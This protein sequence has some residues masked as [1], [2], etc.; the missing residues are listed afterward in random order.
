MQKKLVFRSLAVALPAALFF[1]FLPMLVHADVPTFSDVCVGPDADC[2]IPPFVVS[3]GIVTITFETQVNA[4]CRRSSTDLQWTGM[5]FNCSG[6]QGTT[7]HNCTDPANFGVGTH[8][9]H[10]ACSDVA[11]FEQNITSDN[12]DVTFTVTAADTTRPTI[13]SLTHNPAGDPPAGSVNFQANASDSGSGVK[14]ISVAEQ[15]N[16]GPFVNVCSVTFA[17]P[18]PSA[19]CSNSSTYAAGDNVTL[20]AFAVDDAGNIS[21]AKSDSFTVTAGGGLTVIAGANPTTITLPGSTSLTGF[22]S[23]GVSPYSYLW[24]KLSGPG[25]VTFS[26]TANTSS[27]SASFSTD[28]TYALRLQVVDSAFAVKTGNV[29]ITVLPAG[30]ALDA[31]AGPDQT[32]ADSDSVPGETNVILDG[33]ASTGPIVVYQWTESGVFL[34]SGKT[35]KLP[36]ISDGSHTYLLTVTDGG[37]DADTDAVIVTVNPPGGIPPTADFTTSVSGLDVTVTDDSKPGSFGTL[38][39]AAWAWDWDDGS[40]PELGQGPHTHTYAAAK[41]YNI[42]LSLVDGGGFSDST[43]R[44]VS[45]GVPGPVCPNNVCETGEDATSCPDDCSSGAGGMEGTE[46]NPCVGGGEGACNAPLACN[47]SGICATGG[48][49]VL[50]PTIN[51]TFRN[52]INATSFTDLI[53]SLIDLIFTIAVI[54]APIILV[55]AGVIFMTAAGDPGRVATARRML[56]WTIVGFGIIV[57]AK[58]LVEVLKAILGI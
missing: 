10:F 11:T 16:G 54:V 24:T 56:L 22:A 9:R 35:L 19:A 47:T 34:G 26:P 20:S 41:V 27:P 1:A 40:P 8:T 6:G 52:P 36:F 28:G 29:T 25:N 48:G 45:V 58:G 43:S 15:V 17:A 46:G 42:T 5:S 38:A 51:L 31:K 18:Q 14:T 2:T 13:T 50:S 33:S 37:A 53:N 3:P 30:G 4:E 39:G 44:P 12:L 32:K 7:F 21:P 55:V 57:V 23:G 49:P